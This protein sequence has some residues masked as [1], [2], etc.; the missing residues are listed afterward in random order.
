MSVS[1]SV[2]AS[3]IGAELMVGAAGGWGKRAC[4]LVSLVNS[5]MN[6]YNE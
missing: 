4:H 1:V 6:K 2:S 5:I 3:M